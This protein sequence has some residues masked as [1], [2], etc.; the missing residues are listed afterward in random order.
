MCEEWSWLC[1]ESRVC[2]K[3]RRI[4]EDQRANGVRSEISVSEDW[5]V[6]YEELRGCVRNGE[7]CLRNV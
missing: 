1:E 5:K 2:E 6:A 3:K 4:Y 7:G